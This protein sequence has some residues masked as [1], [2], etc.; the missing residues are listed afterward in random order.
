MLRLL[1]VRE[2]VRMQPEAVFPFHA[3][4]ILACFWDLPLTNIGFHSLFLLLLFQ[5]P[6]LLHEITVETRLFSLLLLQV[7]A[8]DESS[9]VELNVMLFFVAES[10]INYT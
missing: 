6:P 8:G 3:L 5:R 9:S 1:E 10:H 7:D 4:F 2:K